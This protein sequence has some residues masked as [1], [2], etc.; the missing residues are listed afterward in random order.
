MGNKVHPIGLRLGLNQE[1]QARWFA[2]REYAQYLL[3]DMK[4]RKALQQKYR[5]AG[6]SRV[7]IERQSNIINVTLHTSRPGVVIGR[8][9]QR[10]EEVR[11]HLEKVT[12]NK[13]KLTIEEIRQPEM[14]AYLVAKGVA[15]Q[16]ERRIAFR[17]AIKQAIARTIQ[18][19]AKGIRIMCSGRLGG[20]EI[21]R[22]QTLKEGRLPLQTLRANIDFGLAEAR[23]TMGRIGVKV[24]IY[25]GDIIPEKKAQTIGG[26]DAAAHKG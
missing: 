24:W 19:G 12:G 4:V 10:V 17:R 11:Q 8:G 1:W 25:K 5:E 22:R 21:A 2:E 15:E 6:V 23:T 13:V 9:G 7:D 26:T 3:E 18:A 14:D 20:G 16:M